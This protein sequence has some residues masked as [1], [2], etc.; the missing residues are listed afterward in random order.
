VSTLDEA[1]DTIRPWPRIH[2]E[3]QRV[4]GVAIE[5]RRLA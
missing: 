3:G 4:A 2:R 1:I 5:V